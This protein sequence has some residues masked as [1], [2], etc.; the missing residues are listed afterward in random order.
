MCL[1]FRSTWPMFHVGDVV[2]HLAVLLERDAT[3]NSNVGGDG[4]RPRGGRVDAQ[5]GAGPD[6]AG[7]P[8]LLAALRLAEDRRD[9]HGADG[10]LTPHPPKTSWTVGHRS[11]SR[12]LATPY[13]PARVGRARRGPRVRLAS[14]R[15]PPQKCH[16]AVAEPC[17]AGPGVLDALRGPGVV[18]RAVS[19]PAAV[20]TSNAHPVPGTEGAQARSGDPYSGLSSGALKRLGPCAHIV[21]AIESRTA[22]ARRAKRAVSLTG[23]VAQLVEHVTENHGVGG[24]T[25]PLATRWHE[26]LGAVLSRPRS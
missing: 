7:V 26:D 22:S 14:A 6:R 10:Y 16:G 3:P 25:P 21:P 8:L 11:A 23:Q 13:A 17:V 4:P 15:C 5:S 19:S 9:G 20:R 18:V 2:S 1:G 12:V 24:S